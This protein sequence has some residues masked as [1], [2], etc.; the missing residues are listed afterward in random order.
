MNARR[1]FSRGAALALMTAM[2]LLVM[3][4]R[5]PGLSTLQLDADEVWSVWQA[6]DGPAQIVMRTPYDWTPTYFLLMGGWTS[7]VS[8]HP[9]AVRMLALLLF[10]VGAACTYQAGRVLGGRKTGVTFAFAYTAL[11]YQLFISTYP[12]GSAAAVALLPVVLWITLR[13]VQR[14]TWRRA[15]AA[16]LCS[17]AIV[18]VYLNAP[19]ALAFLY[20]FLF[21]LYGRRAVSLWKPVL[22]AGV[23]VLPVLVPRLEIAVSRT[24]ATQAQSTGGLLADFAAFLGGTFDQSWPLWLAL[25]VVMAGAALLTARRA[26]LNR[27]LLAALV[28]FVSGPIILYALNRWLGFFTPH[29]AWWVA[30]SFAL[31]LAALAQM[32]KP[33]WVVAVVTAMGALMFF[34][35]DRS[36]HTIETPPVAA[37]FGWLQERLQPGDVL[38]IDPGCACPPAEVWDYYRGVYFPSGLSQTE[39]PGSARRVWYLAANGRQD[40]E[41]QAQVEAGRLAGAF[42]GPWDF[43]LRLYEGPPDPVGIAFDN[44]LRLHGVVVLPNRG[45]AQETGII[46]R[47]EGEPVRVQIWWSADHPL[48]RDYSAGLYVTSGGQTVAEVNGPPAPLNGSAQTSA[49]EPGTLYVEERTLNLPDSLAS[50]AYDLLL[51]TYYWEEP[52]PTPAEGHPDG[53]I[54]AASFEVK[55][56]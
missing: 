14:P 1:D 26:T 13:Y 53:L 54:P 16:G 5:L 44:G 7:L 34:P 52:T 23:L 2:L 37:A 49:W 42:I 45:Q 10:T 6:V 51:S 36:L 29:Y 4:T 21:T 30:T 50:G 24:S 3:L 19:V 32:L 20:L 48:E 39:A 35:Y 55:A 31:L 9:L 17:A 33:A 38:V 41:L 11:S 22:L 43:L 18:Y 8:N 46:V 28:W 56:W 12:R 15:A 27:L 40:A 25:L 47:R